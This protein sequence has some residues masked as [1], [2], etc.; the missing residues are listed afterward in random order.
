MAL[1]S[2][3]FGPIGGGGGGGGGDVE[4]STHEDFLNDDE[5]TFYHSPHPTTSPGS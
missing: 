3:D 1:I 2:S 4:Y 5:V